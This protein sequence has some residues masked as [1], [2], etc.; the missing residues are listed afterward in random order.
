MLKRGCTSP[1]AATVLSLAFRSL[2]MNQHHN[3]PAKTWT[4][5]TTLVWDLLNKLVS[6]AAV[7]GDPVGALRTRDPRGTSG[8]LYRLQCG[9]RVVNTNT[10][11]LQRIQKY[12]DHD[13]GLM[14]RNGQTHGTGSGD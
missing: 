13:F 10:I 3:L 9:L 6:D 8:A 4:E 11:G 5:I 2:K 12:R 7:M 14:V 1:I